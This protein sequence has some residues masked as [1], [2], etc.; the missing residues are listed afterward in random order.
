[1]TVEVIQ[2]K[3]CKYRP[4]KDKTDGIIFQY[5][6]PGIMLNDHTVN[7]DWRCPFLCANAFYNEMPPDDFYCKYGELK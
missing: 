3:D 1:M 7:F 6:A 2:C 4:V 5:A